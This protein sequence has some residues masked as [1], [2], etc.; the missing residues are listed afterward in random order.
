MMIPVLILLAVTA[1]PG[2]LVTEEANLTAGLLSG[3][4]PVFRALPAGTV[5]APAPAFGQRRELSGA[6]LGKWAAQQGLGIADLPSICVFRR[7]V[8]D[9]EIAWEGELR[10]A[11]ESLFQFRPGP[12]ELTVLDH[13]VSAGPAGRLIL[14]R[15]GLS[16][17]AR[18]GQ[19]LWR[20]KLVAGNQYAG[21]RVRFRIARTEKRLVLARTLPAGHLLT[22]GDVAWESFPYR[23]ELGASQR[24]DKIGANQVLRR[25]LAKG[26]PLL[27]Q[28]LAEAPVIFAGDAVELRSTVGEAT[29]RLQG[30]ARGKARRG[31]SLLVAVPEGNRL[32]R[33]IAVSPGVAEISSKRERTLP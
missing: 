15:G 16:Y 17:D 31:D 33:A 8:E 32:L 7:S 2:C 30:Q 21:A 25:S 1:E 24:L 29:V 28:H 23:L 26:T 27:A 3:R 14:E 10:E 5:L 4:L 12:G 6:V 9:G 20:G 22:A 13:Q 11:L 18:N 19:Y